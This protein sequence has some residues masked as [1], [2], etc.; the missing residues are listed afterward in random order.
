MWSLSKKQNYHEW[1]EI[2]KSLEHKQF[3]N[4]VCLYIRWWTWNTYKLLS[5]AIKGGKKDKHEAAESKKKLVP[6]GQTETNFNLNDMN[7]L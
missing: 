6:K 5:T 7:D 1:Y 4:G 2:K 3:M